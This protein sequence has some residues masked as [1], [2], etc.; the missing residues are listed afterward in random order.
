MVCGKGQIEPTP[1]VSRGEIPSVALVTQI[2]RF[3]LP[4]RSN[5]LREYKAKGSTRPSGHRRGLRGG[6]H[7][8]VLQCTVQT[9]EL[10]FSRTSEV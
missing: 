3:R 2:I 9:M 8:S 7:C 10:G 6:V 5:L 1:S 4:E